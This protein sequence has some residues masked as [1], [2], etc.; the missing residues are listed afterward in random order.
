M[1]LVATSISPTVAWPWHLRNL[2]ASRPTK[3]SNCIHCKED[4][5]VTDL[6][7]RPICIYCAMDRGLVAVED[8]PFT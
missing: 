3:G 5:A 8:V 7:T 2:D 6:N 4:V 1:K